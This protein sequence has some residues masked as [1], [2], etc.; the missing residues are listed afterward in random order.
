MGKRKV[1]QD[2]VAGDKVTIDAVVTAV[3]DDKIHLDTIETEEGVTPQ[4]LVLT[5][6]KPVEGE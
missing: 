1:S 6:T 3:E 4:R 2:L 5:Y